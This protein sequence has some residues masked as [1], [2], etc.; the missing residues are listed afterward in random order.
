MELYGIPTVAG[1][2][3]VDEIRSCEAAEAAGTMVSVA[4]PLSTG[5]TPL[6]GR[7]DES[8]SEKAGTGAAELVAVMVATVAAVTEGAWNSP[9]LEMLPTLVFHT[10]PVWAVPV[11]AAVNCRLSDAFTSACAGVI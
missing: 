4:D 3:E 11:T 6:G 9:V 10:T 1:G 2:R 7:T 5:D 8:S